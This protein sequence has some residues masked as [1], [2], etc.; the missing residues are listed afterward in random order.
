MSFKT[1]QIV[2]T[3][4]ANEWRNKS[5]WYDLF[6]SKSLERHISGDWGDIEQEDKEANDK[7]IEHGGRLFS[8]YITDEGGTKIWIIT[9]W[10]RSATNI[11]FPH[12]Y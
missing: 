5:F 2:I 6:I 4:G 11:L 12:E 9:E 10:D 1:G 7:A 3:H 8:S